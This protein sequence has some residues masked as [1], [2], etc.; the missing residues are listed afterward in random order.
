[1][2]ICTL[3]HICAFAQDVHLYAHAELC[4]CTFSPCCT[5]AQDV[6]FHADAHLLGGKLLNSHFHPLC[7]T[8]S[9]FSTKML[10][11]TYYDKN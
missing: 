10:N 4:F 8:I 9:P 7:F 5:F 6:H 3:M 11:L 1:M 2:Y